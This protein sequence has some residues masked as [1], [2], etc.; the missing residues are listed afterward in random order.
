MR[1]IAGSILKAEKPNIVGMQRGACPALAAPMQT[2]D[3]LLVRLRPAGGTLSISQFR[4]LASAAARHGN[5]VVEITARGNLQIRGLQTESVSPLAGEIDA[6]GIIIPDGVA[7]EISPL[8][9]ID[10]DEFADAA[11]MEAMLRSK[12]G[13]L[14]SSRHLAPKL[15][16][17]IDGG[18]R[19][20]LSALVADIRVVAQPAGQWLVSIA[21]DEEG[22]T[23]LTLGTADA[24]VGAVGDL[25]QTLIAHGRRTR[26]RDIDKAKLRA[27]FREF[28]SIRSIG[29]APAKASFVGVTKLR[30]G[31]TIL[32][33]RLKFGQARATDLIS[34]LTSAEGAGAREIRLAPDR[35]FFVI[36]LA[37]TA[38][39]ALLEAAIC[40][41]FSVT[42]NEPTEQIAACAG[43]G[44]CGA[45]FYDTKA[46]ASQLIDRIPAL[47]DDSLKLHLSGCAKG[48]AH[49]RADL[50]IVGAAGG[51]DFVVDGI[52]AD[53]PAAR[54]AGGGI[55]F[56]IERLA[57]LIE[58][59]RGAGESSADCLKRLGPT[60]LAEALQQE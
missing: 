55:D 28:D 25:L 57:R 45:A 31:R 29:P 26:A 39:P 40:C 24:A 5:G 52:A 17:L 19:F 4:H 12:L 1:S 20:S 38:M 10:A 27:H 44:A 51:Y 23:P 54:I 22:A 3:G 16:I 36:D 60:G 50:A 56:A 7:V 30:N 37:E 34:F 59:K 42:A 11:D 21:G 18:G 9:G 41:G 32:G 49:R 53:E 58:E 8:H 48:C 6:A 14:L 33:V 47:F 43:A 13:D 46:L 35:G 2:G 15:S